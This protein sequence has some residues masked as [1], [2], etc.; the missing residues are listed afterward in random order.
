MIWKSIIVRF[1][2]GLLTSSLLTLFLLILSYPAVWLSIYGPPIGAALGILLVEIQNL[3]KVIAP[4][5]GAGF[6]SFFMSLVVFSKT[7]TIADDPGSLR[8]LATYIVISNI[9]TNFL[10]FLFANGKKEESSKNS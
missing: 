9:V 6:I 5:I 4:I 7:Y 1:L 10:F 8:A 2:T 3:K